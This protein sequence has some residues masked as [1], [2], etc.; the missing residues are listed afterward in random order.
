VAVE[1]D[2]SLKKRLLHLCGKAIGTYHLIEEG[3]VI[4]IA[5]SGGKDSFTLM[6]LLLELQAK[7]PIQFSLRVVHLDQKQPGYPTGILEAYLT[8]KGIPHDILEED[9]YRIVQDKIKPGDTLCSLCSRLR[10]G[11]LYRHCRERGANKLA[12][13]HH[14]EDLL[15]TFLLNLFF[16]GSLKTMPPQVLNDAGDVTVIRPLCLVPE[17][18]IAAYAA[19]RDFP[20]IPCNLCGSQPNLQRA[21]AKRLLKE[22]EEQSPGRLESMMTALKNPVMSHLLC[23]SDSIF[24]ERLR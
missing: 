14:R 18:D 21:Q 19:T 6:E 23:P 12:L 3:D 4:L 9:T 17:G 24:T 11:I 10:R 20:I 22:W 2:P 1:Q 5:L 16:S 15:E 7:A 8:E 13:G